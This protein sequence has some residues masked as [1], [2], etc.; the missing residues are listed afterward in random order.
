MQSKQVLIALILCVCVFSCKQEEKPKVEPVKVIIEPEPITEF[1]FILKDFIVKRDT[2]K[3][4]DSFGEILERNHIGYP[5]I[6]NIAENAKDSF[7]IRRLQVGKPYTLLCKNDSL[8]TPEC[9]IYQPNSIDYVVIKFTDSIETYKGKKPITLVERIASG[10]VMNNL[11]ETMESQGLPYQ[12][13]NDMSDIYAWTIDFFR[14]QK[15]DRYSGLYLCRN[16][17]YR[18]CL[19]ST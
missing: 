6:F 7:D 19:F 8:Q 13:I 15:G 2:I 5:R 17:K 18:C 14:L 9:F 16:R 12:L 10:I 3:S 4:G 1:G 11:S